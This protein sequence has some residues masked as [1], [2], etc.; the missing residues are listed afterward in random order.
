MPQATNLIVKNAANVDKTFTL[1]TPAPGDG[2]HAI[3][4]LKEGV[5]PNVFPTFRA[6]ARPLGPN[7]STRVP[8]RYASG[9]LTIGQPVTDPSTGLIIVHDGFFFKFEAGIRDNFPETMRDDAAAFAGNLVKTALITA[10][11]R[12]GF[13]AN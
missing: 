13:P 9:M 6:L 8:G 5:A 2:T 4:Q 12:D 11:I 3:W 1:Q 7:Q 10:M